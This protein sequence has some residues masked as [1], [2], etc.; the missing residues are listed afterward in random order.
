MAL[1]EPKFKRRVT[2]QYCLLII[3]ILVVLTQALLWHAALWPPQ[4][5]VPGTSRAEL[6]ALEGLLCPALGGH[7][8]QHQHIALCSVRHR[9]RRAECDVRCKARECGCEV[10]VGGRRGSQA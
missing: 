4:H 7:V 10:M 6:G 1:T 5:K 8:E 3:L 2:A 9:G